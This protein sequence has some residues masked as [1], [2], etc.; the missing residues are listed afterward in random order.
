MARRGWARAPRHLGEAAAAYALFALLGAL[1]V[2]WASAIGAALGGVIGPLLPVHRRGLD[3]L[4]R[5]LPE[6]SPAEVRRCARRMWRHLGRVAAEYPHLHRFSVDAP[7]GRIELVGRAHLDEARRSANGGIFF[8]GHIGNWEIAALTLEQG[9]IPA[10]VVYRAANNPIVD[11]MIS[12]FREPVIRRRVRKGRD[13]VRELVSVLGAGEHVG[14]LVDQKLNTGIPVPFFGRDAMTA[15]AAATFALRYDCPV[16]PVRVERLRGASFRIT[17]Y[18]KLA[19]PQE[20]TR[21]ERVRAIMVAINRTLEDWIRERPEQ[22]L[23]L[24]RRWPD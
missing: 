3:N 24:H 16:W 22:W 21:E 20:G 23:W 12:R 11:R 18:P 14:L 9:G 1:P 6:L 19:I 10:T 7:G 4:T 13:S 5:S 15:P 8:S 17:V 2:G